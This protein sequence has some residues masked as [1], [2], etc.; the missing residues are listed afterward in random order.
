MD[1]I[2]NDTD[3]QQQCGSKILEKGFK[4]QCANL[5]SRTV[6]IPTGLHYFAGELKRSQSKLRSTIPICGVHESGLKSDFEK[7]FGKG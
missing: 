4:V 6:T 2:F 7:L 1:L 5:T 3:Y